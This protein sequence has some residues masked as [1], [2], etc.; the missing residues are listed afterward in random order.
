MRTQVLMGVVAVLVAVNESR[1]GDTT[2]QV[3]ALIREA[4]DLR[5]AGRD[6]RAL[7]LLQRAYDLAR[8]PRTAAQLGL[9]NMALGYWLDAERYLSESLPSARHPWV[10]KNRPTLEN[11]LKRVSANIGEVEVT[12]SPTGARVT[13][14]REHVGNLPLARPLRL[15]AGPHDLKVSA[16]GYVSRGEALTVA[17][18]TRKS[19]AIDLDASSPSSLPS[20]D[21]NLVARPAAAPRPTI[22][23]AR[24]TEPERPRATARRTMAWASAGVAAASL[25]VGLVETVRWLGKLHSFDGHQGVLADGSGRSGANCGI[26][27]TNFGGAGC[28]PLHSELVS[29]RTFSVVGYGLGAAFGAGAAILFATSS[30]QE[31]RMSTAMSC[32]PDVADRGLS[33]RAEIAF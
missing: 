3:E 17:G 1:A 26:D 7:P 33:C 24:P 5:Q 20:G 13:I 14:D 15:N 12:G 31:P 28:A 2:P 6:A 4:I 30:K 19:V 25:A 8:T 21:A 32:Q 16:P 9:C 11:A 10:E 27:E 18:A 29:A 23:E 22:V